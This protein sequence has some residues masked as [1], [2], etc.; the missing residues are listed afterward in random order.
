[1]TDALPDKKGV[2]KTVLWHQT[3]MLVGQGY[4]LTD[5]AK[6][7]GCYRETISVYQK[8]PEWIALRDEWAERGLARMEPVIQ[9]VKANALGAHDQVVVPVLVAIATGADKEIKEALQ[10]TDPVSGDPLWKVRQSAKELQA[11]TAEALGN[12]PVIR[13]LFGDRGVAGIGAAAQSVVQVILHDS[14]EGLH[15]EYVTDDAVDAAP[16][17]VQEEGQ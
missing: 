6:A 14:P 8:D 11:R 4:S 17:D 10:A 15:V 7:V 2:K 9:R 13:A 3:A 1:M 16:E 5:A 12:L